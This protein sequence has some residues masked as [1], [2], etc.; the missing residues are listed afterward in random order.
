MID[1]PPTDEMF[2]MKSTEGCGNE[3]M[4]FIPDIMQIR[5]CD[6]QTAA[7]WIHERSVGEVEAY[8]IEA[9]S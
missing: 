2:A 6:K 8:V 5:D 9:W 4:H 3:A 7:R 1:T